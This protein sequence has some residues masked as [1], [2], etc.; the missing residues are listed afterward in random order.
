LERDLNRRFYFN[1][2]EDWEPTANKKHFSDRQLKVEVVE[3]GIV[4]PARLKGEE[5]EGAVCDK[6]FNFVAGYSRTETGE[7]KRSALGFELLM[8]YTVDRKELTYLD[9]DVI[10]GGVLM[11]DFGH[12]ILECFTRLWYVLPPPKS[13]KL[14]DTR[15]IVFVVSRVGHRPYFDDFFRLMGIAKER[16][17]YV[18]KPMQFHSVAVPEQSMYMNLS[19][20]KEFLIPY[21]AI[22]KNV[23]PGK[24]KKIYLSRKDFEVRKRRNHNEQYFEDFLVAHGFKSISPEKLSIEEQ[25]SFILGADEIAAGTGTL[26]HWALFCRPA[27]KFIQLSRF[28]FY[29]GWQILV[30]D[31]T[32]VDAYVVDV[33]KNFLPNIGPGVYFFAANKCWQEFVAD[34]FGEQIVVNDDS[35]C[36]NE[37]LERY[38]TDWFKKYSGNQNLQ[39]SSVK[40]LCDR[41]GHEGWGD[42]R[43]ENQSSNYS[44]KRYDIQGLKI[45]FTAPLCKVYY[46]VYYNE[47]EGW[48]QE[49]TNS[50][51][52]GSVGKRKPIFG[53]KIRLDE[54]GGEKFDILYRVHKFD[55]TWSDWAKNGAEIISEDKKVLTAIQIKL[56]TKQIFSIELDKPNKFI[57]GD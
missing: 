24:Y 19:Y 39:I 42:W 27:V 51:L 12:F 20:T 25:L 48:T 14:E 44:N 45:D 43:I 22:R 31:A 37:E 32:K 2:R 9:E 57:V 52:A 6:D 8:S 38:V 11:G 26:T 47:H 49:V 7:K 33:S 16:I 46:S 10:F 50:Q 1:N 4:L 40:K 23:T 15:K 34:Y 28:P 53:I 13:N 36:F 30:N 54:V 21:A 55:G 35:T 18:E 3:N 5:W 17:V 41:V 29:Y 56:E